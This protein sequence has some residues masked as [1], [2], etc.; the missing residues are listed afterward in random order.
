MF[1]VV[2]FLSETL[3]ANVAFV[4][5]F[6]CMNPHVVDKV[7]SLIEFP[8]AIVV[9]SD[10]ISED[11]SCAFVMLVGCLIHVV[12]HGRNVGFLHIVVLWR[13]TQPFVVRILFVL[14]ETL[15]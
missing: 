3:S 7:P 13:R 6:A 11:P 15:C 5:L 4:R 10:E 9:L 12:L 1:V 2:A 8:I 14:V